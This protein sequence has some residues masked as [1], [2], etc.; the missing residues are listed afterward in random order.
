MGQASRPSSFL[1]HVV[2]GRH[3]TGTETQACTHDAYSVRED[4]LVE[5]I[6]KQHVAAKSKV[7]Q[8]LE[9]MAH[10]FSTILKRGAGH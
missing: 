3:Y 2:R 5:K 4:Q 1:D 8:F 6:T 7:H 10:V 9:S